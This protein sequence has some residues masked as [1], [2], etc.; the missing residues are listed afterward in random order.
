MMN[1]GVS[2]DMLGVDRQERRCNDDCELQDDLCSRVGTT[3]GCRSC[4]QYSNDGCEDFDV[5]TLIHSGGTYVSLGTRT[6]HCTMA[7]QNDEQLIERTKAKT[8]QRMC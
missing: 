2:R 4:F 6:K 8:A 1:D 3:S 7:K 5:S